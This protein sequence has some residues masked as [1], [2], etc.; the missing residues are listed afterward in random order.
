MK[1][2]LVAAAALLSVGIA[3]AQEE[4]GP[5][6]GFS[7]G[8]SDYQDDDLS[9]GD[10]ATAYRIFG[11]YQLNETLGIEVG[12]GTTEDLEESFGFV[13]PFAGNVSLTIRGEYE[14][15]T[16]RVI[17]VA[18]LDAINL[19]GGAGYYEADVSLTAR[20]TDDFGTF[21]QTLEDSNSGLSLIGGIEYAFNR[22]K[23]RG[24]Y[25]WFD[26]DGEVEAWTI[27]IGL[28]VQF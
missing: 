26:T 12:F 10:S 21:T 5:Y 25:E 14:V 19:F 13:D 17:G 6:L 18:P 15:S 16:L 8:S 4:S 2:W 20:L 23:L 27:A 1:R 28:R 22:L 11:G 7:V 9:F 24:E 3:Q